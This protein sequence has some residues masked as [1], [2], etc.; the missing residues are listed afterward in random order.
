MEILTVPCFVIQTIGSKIQSCAKAG[1]SIL[2][3]TGIFQ[4]FLIPKSYQI[5][6]MFES[7]ILEKLMYWRIWLCLWLIYSFFSQ[8]G[9]SVSSRM[10]E[11]VPCLPTDPISHDTDWWLVKEKKG[12]VKFLVRCRNILTMRKL[13][14]GVRKKR[15]KKHG[16]LLRSLSCGYSRR[17][18]PFQPAALETAVHSGTNAKQNFFVLFHQAEK[19]LFDPDYLKQGILV[20]VSSKNAR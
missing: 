4:H 5:V 13:T 11:L 3:K 9:A 18:W 16:S 12:D 1:I 15:E 6:E 10:G 8:A 2:Q 7:L 14:V 19:N 20:L 17:M